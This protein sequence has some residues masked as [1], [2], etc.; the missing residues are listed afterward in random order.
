MPVREDALSDLRWIDT[1]FAAARP[2]AMAALFAPDEEGLYL[3]IGIARVRMVRT[4][5]PRVWSHVSMPASTGETRR[6]DI[7]VFTA[8]GVLALELAPENVELLNF[9]AIR[10]LYRGEWKEGR[11]YLLRA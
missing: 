8:D 11:E 7:R 2:Q 1:A 9:A 10:H 4:P 3:P 5:G 6:D